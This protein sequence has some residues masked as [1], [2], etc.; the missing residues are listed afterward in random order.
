MDVFLKMLSIIFWPGRQQQGSRDFQLLERFKKTCQTFATLDQVSGLLSYRQA[1]SQLSSLLQQTI[2][3]PK[4]LNEPVQIMGLL[5]VTGL[6]FDVAWVIGMDDQ[7]LPAA[8]KPHPLIPFSIQQR[9]DL[10]HATASRE[11][12]FAKHIIA[13]LSHA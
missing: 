6:T 11:L 4:S 8:T 7:T 10:P 5:E 2:F 1:L 13:R 3:Q 12:T 9:Y